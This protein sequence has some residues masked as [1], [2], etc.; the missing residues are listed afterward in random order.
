MS[1]GSPFSLILWSVLIVFIN[2]FIML[3]YL[4]LK[5]NKHFYNCSIAYP[6]VSSLPIILVRVCCINVVILSLTEYYFTHCIENRAGCSANTL[7]KCF[8]G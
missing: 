1:R 7:K 6:S 4:Y 8:S 5:K 2:P 3:I